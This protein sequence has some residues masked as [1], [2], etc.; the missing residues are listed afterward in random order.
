MPSEFQNINYAISSNGFVLINN[1]SINYSQDTFVIE[2]MKKYKK[3][4]LG[5]SI[6]QSI[7]FLPN[8]I[9]HLQLGRQFNKPIM[10]L[11]QTLKNLIIASNELSYCDFNQSLDY[12]PEG[13]ECLSIRL[14]RVFNLPINYLPVSLKK[15]EIICRE[16]THPINNLPDGLEH[17]SISKFDYYNT[18]NL[19]ANLKTFNF[20][21]LI[22]LSEDDRDIIN[23]NFIKKYPNIEF[24]NINN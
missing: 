14:N 4:I 9:F 19:P 7:D 6:N 17:I 2:L 22:K 24:N 8:G 21:I 15:L 20:H 18:H 23:N 11:P 5:D 16:F 10:N 12:L 13:L 3:V 1:N